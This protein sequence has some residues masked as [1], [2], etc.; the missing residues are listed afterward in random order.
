[1]PFPGDRGRSPARTRSPTTSRSTP[2]TTTSR[3]G[4]A[5]AVESLDAGAPAAA[6]SLRT[7]AGTW[8]CDNVVVATGTFGRTPSVPDFAADLDP[9]ILQLHSSEYRRPGQLRDGARPRRRRVP[10]RHRHRLRG[11]ADPADHAV[12]PRLRRDPGRLESWRMKVVFPVHGLRVAARR[13]AAYARSAA[14]RCATSA[15]TAARCSASSARTSPSAASSG[16]EPGRRA[17]ATGCRCSPTARRRRR[18]RRVGDRLPAG[19]RLDQPA[20]HRRGRLAARVPRRRRRR[21][22]ASSSAACPS[23]TPSPRWS[24]AGVGRDAAYVAER[25]RPPHRGAQRAARGG[26]TRSP[27]RRAPVSSTEEVRDGRGRRAG[28]AR[29]RP[30]SAATGRPRTTV[31][32]LDVPRTLSADD[33]R[34]AGHGGLPAAA[35]ATTRVETL[36]AGVPACTRRR[37]PAA[38][39]PLRLPPRR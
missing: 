5:C 33:L 32:G 26:L 24:V 14:R 15:S 29:A 22:R 21:A 3:S 23:S 10:L 18:Q 2:R 37:R 16:N 4:S 31:V 35:G 8:T 19:V 38:A 9:S 30:T 13:H 7:D 12:R 6:T 36:P 20:G 25:P 11:R 1:M 17:S 34:E 27:S 28:S 39:V